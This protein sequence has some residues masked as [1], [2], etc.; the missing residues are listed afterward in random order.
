MD[1]QLLRYSM[2]TQMSRFLE[3]LVFQ[4]FFAQALRVAVSSYT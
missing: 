2:T 3:R 1:G 4:G